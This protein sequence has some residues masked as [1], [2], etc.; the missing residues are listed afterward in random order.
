MTGTEMKDLLDG[1]AVTA[2]D[3]TGDPVAEVHRRI[4]RRRPAR[5][6]VPVLVA[7]A[8]VAAVLAAVGVVRLTGRSERPTPP[9]VPPTPAAGQAALNAAR[10]FTTLFFTFD[11]RTIDRYS[12]DVEAGS[13]GTFRSDFQR[14]RRELSLT[15]R[16]ARGV[17]HGTV[18]ASAARDV[19]PSTAT[20]LVVADQSETNAIAPT[21]ATSR[22]RLL[23]RLNLV[24]GRWLVRDLSP[25]VAA[26]SVPCTDGSTLLTQ[27]CAAISRLFGFDYHTLDADLAAQQAVATGA[28]T[29]QLATQNGPQLR[30]LARRDHVVTRITAGPAAVER[31]DATSAVVL[32][33][34]NRTVSSDV[35]KQPRVDRNRLEVSLT[36]DGDRWL[37]SGVKAL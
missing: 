35:Q 26:G 16:D 21:S 25:V 5:R 9:A 34:V 23:E 19:T 29:A 4:G 1:L 27:A 8:T 15:L 31:Q 17:T 18:L 11:Y 28:Y 32:A 7:L 36:R 10:A 3:P 33:F 6:L 22:F 37:V 24:D 12:D 20:V 30:S 14:K 2:P 13:T